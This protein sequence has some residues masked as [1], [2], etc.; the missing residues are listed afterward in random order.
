MVTK[1][2]TD[3]NVVHVD[4]HNNNMIVLLVVIK[5][6]AKGNVLLYG[7]CND[8]TSFVAMIFCNNGRVEGSSDQ[9]GVQG[10]I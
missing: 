5:F 7:I 9:M 3:I 1:N 8:E 2:T 4:K 10:T 6:C